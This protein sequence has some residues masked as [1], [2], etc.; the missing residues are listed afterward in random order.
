MIRTSTTPDHEVAIIGAGFSGIGAAIKLDQAGFGDYVL[1]EDDEGMLA[2]DNV[3][4]VLTV[5]LSEVE[6]LSDLLDA[7]SATLTTDGLTELNRRFDVDVEDAD[8]IAASHLED[9]GLL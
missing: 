5:E 9:A 4:P 7:I 3:V 6:G 2:A 8:A 1:L